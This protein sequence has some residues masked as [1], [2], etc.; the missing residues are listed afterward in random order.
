MSIFKTQREAQRLRSVL[1]VVR[2]LNG[3]QC[4]GCEI[5]LMNFSGGAG[6]REEDSARK[7]TDASVM[8]DWSLANS[9]TRCKMGLL[10]SS[11]FGDL[12]GGELR[13]LDHVRA[14]A[15][16]SAH[17]TVLLAQPGA[18]E[19][20]LAS[21]GTGAEIIRWK[22][23]TTYPM[24]QVY[25][26][27]AWLR[28][29]VALRRLKPALV[30]CNTFFDLETTGK[31]AAHLRL[32]LVWRARADTFPNTPYWPTGREERL[33]AFLNRRVHGIAAT[34]HYEAQMMVR[35]GVDPAKVRV[36]HNGVD[37]RA[38]G[39]REAGIQLRSERGIAPGQFVI[40]FVARMVPQKGYDVFFDALALLKARGVSFRALVAGDTTLLEERAD[41]YRRELREQVEGLGLLDAVDFL[42]FRKDIP[43]VMGAADVFAMASLVEPFGNTVIEAMASGRPVVCSDL[44]GPRESVIDGETGR[45]FPPGDA[46]AMADRLSALYAEPDRRRAMGER[47]RARAEAVFDLQR[48]VAALDA[49]CLD[50]AHGRTLGGH[51]P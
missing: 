34:T 18:L 32:P 33:V 11:W 47:G 37:L 2:E 38:Y 51:A 4:R 41:E 7:A 35:A 40:A 45:F 43:A 50:V 36:I 21:L 28:C 17:T 24:R 30:V 42:G 13:L 15:F 10:Y 9:E 1:I 26:Y 46:E 5:A 3:S 22:G 8:L 29:L 20:E 12:G 31:V 48:N 25:W 39:D 16:R 49:L 44:P 19:Q 6:N 14:T 23:G 27:G